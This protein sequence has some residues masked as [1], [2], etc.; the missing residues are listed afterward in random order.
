MES[1]I[2][3]VTS[4]LVQQPTYGGVLKSETTRENASIFC[5]SDLVRF[6][7]IMQFFLIIPFALKTVCA[8][9]LLKYRPFL[10]VAAGF[11]HL[12]FYIR[13]C[14]SYIHLMPSPMCLGN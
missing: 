5:S 12:E 11:L 9:E 8:V 10:A 7:Q 2:P 4:G 1:Q 13:I 3:L 14:Q 6:L